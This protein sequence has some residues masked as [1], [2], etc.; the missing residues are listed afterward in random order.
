MK[1]QIKNNKIYTSQYKGVF[2]VEQAHILDMDGFKYKIQMKIKEYRIE[3]GWI[4]F[5]EE[6]MIKRAKEL[7]KSSF[8]GTCSKFRKTK[9]TYILLVDDSCYTNYNYSGKKLDVGSDMEMD[10]DSWVVKGILE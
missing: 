8:I 5:D 3:G 7:L 10:V 6:Y 9:H 4:I 1:K 2:M